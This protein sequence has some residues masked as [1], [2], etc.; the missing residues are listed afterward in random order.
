MYKVYK[1]YLTLLHNSGKYRRL[2]TW[3]QESNSELLDFSTNDY[4][5]LSRHRDIIR[6]GEAAAQSYGIGA[7]GSRLLSGN[8]K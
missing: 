8:H 5:N 2:G 1:Q 6:A 7:T 4:L 3:R